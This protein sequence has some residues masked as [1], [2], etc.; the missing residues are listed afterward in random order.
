MPEG[1][2]PYR[3]AEARSRRLDQRDASEISS[4]VGGFFSK[5]NRSFGEA[6]TKISWLVLAVSLLGLSSGVASPASAAAADCPSGGAVRFGVEPYETASKLVPI[7]DRVA[8][9]MAKNLDCEVK[10]FV[11]TNYTAEVEAMRA[12]KLEAGEFSPF[13]YI[14][15]HTLARAEAVAVLADL[16]GRPLTYT[17]G[18]VSWPGSGVT[19]LAQVAGHSFGYSDPASNS[20][21]LFPAYALTKAGID[22]DKGVKPLYSGSHTASYEA[23]RNHKVDVG[24]LNSQQIESS[25]LAGIYK[26]S[27]FTELWRSDPI[28]SD[29]FCVRADLEPGFKARLIKM[30]QTLDL[31]GLPPDDQKTLVGGVVGIRSVPVADN[32]YDVIRD[33]AKVMKIDPAKL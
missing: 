21:H 16:S 30:L 14:F 2:M 4:S 33:V 20:G 11:T 7:Y 13:S 24:E 19:T 28:P 17:A 31:S 29:P 32:F 9:I 25:K 23:L 15:A 6:M 10:V 8:A 22:P 26:E 5:H 27:D 12:G 18:I 1:S 3:N